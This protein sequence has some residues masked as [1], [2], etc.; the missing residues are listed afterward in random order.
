M[1]P[2]QRVAGRKHRGLILMAE[3]RGREAWI[4]KKRLGVFQGA[5]AFQNLEPRV[6]L[7]I[8]CCSGSVA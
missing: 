8:G 6:L 5:S 3:Q 1:Q 2:I 4:R 7:T